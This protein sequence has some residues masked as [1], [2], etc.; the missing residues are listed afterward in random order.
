MGTRSFSRM[1]V[2]GLLLA[3][4]ARCSAQEWVW[5]EAEKPTRATFELRID[6]GPQADQLSDGAWLQ[7]GLSAEEVSAGG[8]AGGREV[9]YA[10]SIEETGIYRFWM[11]LG[12]EFARAPFRWRLDGGQWHD[13]SASDLTTNLIG[14]AD[15]CEIGW[16]DCG[17]TRLER[18]E[19]ELVIRIEQA[20][21]DGRCIVALDC[22][23]F[24]Q[25]DWMP[26]GPLK[27]N[28]EPASELDRAAAGHVFRLPPSPGGGE[29]LRETMSLGG[30][31]RACRDDDPDMDADPYGPMRSLPSRAVWHGVTIPSALAD[32]PALRLANRVWL[33]SRID[34]PAEYA[35]RSFV[36][37]FAGTNWIA[38]V[39]V[40]GELVGWHKSTRVPWQLD[41]TRAVR[42]GQV[43]EIAVG[44]KDIHYA[45]DSAFHGKQLDELRNMPPVAYQWTRWVAP[46]YPS[47][48]G[49]ADGTAAGITD[50]VSL[51]VA[52]PVYVQDVFVQTS[53]RNMR[54]VADIELRNP[55]E[56]AVRVT[57]NAEA[58]F[59]GTRQVEREFDPVELTVP[60]GGAATAQLAADWPDAKLWWPGDDPAAMYRL[61][62]SVAAGGRVLDVAEQPFGFREVA[63]DG[64]HFRINGIRYNFWNMLSGLVGPTLEDR[65]AHFRAGNNRFERFGAD[66]GLG[67]VL[68]PRRNQLAWTDTHGIPGRLSTM[69][70]GMFITQNLRNPVVWENYR[71]H[72]EQVVRAYRNHPSVIVYSLE[73]ELV[74]IAGRLG[75]GDIIDEVEANARRYLVEPVHALDPTRPCM[76]DGAGA[77]ADQS[78]EINCLHYPE[79]D[80]QYYPEN[81][82]TMERV[83]SF[84]ERWPWDRQRPLAMGEIAFFTGRNADHAWIGGDEAFCGRPEAMRA[85]SRY[86]RTLIEGY[87]WNNVAMICPWAGQD[88]MPD[89]RISMSPLAAFVREHGTGLWSGGETPLT[90]KVFNDTFSEEP[91]RFSWAV[92][93]AGAVMA[94]GSEELTIE[95]GGGQELRLTIPCP[96]VDERVPARLRLRVERPGDEP[97]EDT[98]EMSLLPRAPRVEARRPVFVL[99]GERLVADTVRACGV[100]VREVADVSECTPGGI[101][102]LGPNVLSGASGAGPQLA[103][104]ADSGGRVLCLE[105]EHPLG[106]EAL[107]HGEREGGPET[108]FVLPSTAAD[109]Q[110]YYNFPQGLGSELFRDIG[111]RDLCCWRGSGPTAAGVWRKPESGARSWVQC[112]DQL[113]YSSMLEVPIGAGVMLLSQLRI[114]SRL[115]EEPAAVV[116]L[117]N[118]IRYLDAYTPAT[119]TVGVY[120]PDRPELA[121][122]VGD[123]GVRSEVLSDLAPTFRAGSPPILAVN[124]SARN[125]SALLEQRQLVGQYV[126]RGGWIVLAGLEPDGLAAFNELLGTQHAIREFRMEKVQFNPDAIMAGLGNGDVVMYSDREIMFGDKFLSTE[127]FTYVV[128]GEDVAPFCRVPNQPDGPYQ[129]T[130][131]DHDPYNVVNGMTGLDF[132][133]YILQIWHADWPADG[134][135]PFEFQLPYPTRIRSA[136]IW[137][138][139]YYDT[140]ENMEIQVDGRPVATLALPDAMAPAEVDLGGVATER[141]IGLVV[142]SVRRKG[143]L[144]L[145]GIDNVQFTRELPDWYVGRVQPLVTPGGL[146]K[147]PRGQGGFVLNQLKL[148]GDD[149]A[150]NRAKKVR[151]FGTILR[152]LGAASAPAR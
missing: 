104:Y 61:R 137:N 114:G 70:D 93:A 80:N 134:S 5:I 72:C 29:G 7:A 3:A 106:G 8:L 10:V 147:Y 35:G 11:R 69:I 130:Y 77:L 88:Q 51:V 56:S 115:A 102:V 79:A 64:V 142:R 23:V 97:F 110:A 128:D 46:I 75:H 138:N 146:V 92:E 39:L 36:L 144:P 151:I 2:I 6:R 47:T 109:R 96:R 62:V 82:Y 89:T 119:A 83:G 103:K 131:D 20:A 105:Q 60:A 123:T 68:G 38:S 87:R 150:E 118:A 91:V 133:R 37:D 45:I 74:L 58:V 4:G 26:A 108:Y 149:L 127:T 55:T 86:I 129:P 67:P 49:D 31:W 65:L 112:G 21:P 53:V 139:A 30:P 15:W 44:I 27:P 124:A 18:G 81:A 24:V 98:K 135:P 48:K 52:G 14:L 12:F 54:A 99:S 76:L 111:E 90:V 28:E 16:L 78:L 152:N 71:E 122:H 143:G 121:A 100:E 59:D 85:Y 50:P 1:L 148:A 116:M 84:G 33:V 22:F 120:A 9:A 19:H 17:E 41:I 107:G 132:W 40:N 42:P 145:V 101:L 66:L 126:E 13:V 136:K 73:N 117:A 63:L 95:P 25:G 140:I 125:L 34:V 43:N 141:T 113:G 57:V 32:T 94:Q